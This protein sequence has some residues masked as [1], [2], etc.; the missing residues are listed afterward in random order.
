[1][2]E[3]NI[4]NGIFFDEIVAF[5]SD[6]NHSSNCLLLNVK[7]L[8][9]EIGELFWEVMLRNWNHTEVRSL[10]GWRLFW[11]LKV[12]WDHIF[13]LIG[14][15]FKSLLHDDLIHGSEEVLV[16]FVHNTSG[17]YVLSR[18]K[19]S[20]GGCHV[21]DSTDLLWV[22]FREILD[23][24][25]VD[26]EV[27]SDLRISKNSF[28]VCL[29][30][31]LGKDPW[32]LGIEKEVDSGEFNVF[33]SHI[34][35]TAVDSSFIIPGLDK[36]SFPFTNVA[37]SSEKTLGWNGSEISLFVN[38]KINP[39]RWESAVVL[40]IIEWFKWEPVGLIWLW[41]SII[42]AQLEKEFFD[43]KRG[44]KLSLSIN[45]NLS[46]RF[47]WNWQKR[48]HDLGVWISDAFS[49]AGVEALVDIGVSEVVLTN[50]L[51]GLMRILKLLLLDLFHIWIGSFDA[52]SLRD[53]LFGVSND[54]TR[55][56]RSDSRNKLEIIRVLS[57]ENF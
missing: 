44:K 7:G 14:T 37:V 36:N 38:T 30:N 24:H 54:Q 23:W 39:F 53:L 56:V 27:I 41:I 31:S 57:S 50:K 51:N 28:L 3:I 18:F 55:R 21:D 12:S 15:L 16:Y 33:S 47:T 42:D 26:E 48:L 11:K 5:S 35:L 10:L 22:E 8:E 43:I 32:V 6:F 29:G 34:P 17:V 2:V 1:M 46:W 19:I 40:E 45:Y 13:E 9:A 52:F 4:E 20:R 25:I 49:F